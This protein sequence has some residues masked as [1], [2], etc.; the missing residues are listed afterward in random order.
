MTNRLVDANSPYLLQHAQNPVDWYPWGPEA[1]EKARLEDKPIFLSI[2][3]AA[4][5]WCH[6][7]AH[8]SFEDPETARIL[9]EHFVN[10]KVDRE[11]RP[12]LDSIYMNAVVAMTGSGGWPM[13]LFLTPEG[14]PV[15]G[16]TYFPPQRRYNL[17]AFSEILLTVARL[18]KEDRQRLLESS[19]QIT[20]HLRQNTEQ[21]DAVQPLSSEALEQAVLNLAQAY[22]WKNGGWGRAPK[23]PQPMVIELLLRRAANGD[24]FAQEM[25]EHV[26]FAM[27]RG[28]MY[29]V[30]GG[31][32]ARYSTDERWL[33]PHF[34]K[35]LYDNAQLALAY[36]H[37]FLLTGEPGFRRTCE[38]TLDFVIREMTHP[39]GGFFSNL[40]ADSEGEEGK[41]YLWTLA[42]IRQAIPEAAEMDFLTAAYGLSEAGNFAGRTVLQRQLD[43]ASLAERF[44]IPLAEVPA[45]LARL[46]ANLLRKRIGRTR[47]GTDDKV[48]TA[49]NALMLTAFAE[50]GRYLK[51]S[52]YLE[53]ARR[54]GDFLLSELYN[55][56]KLLRTWRK[57]KAG[58]TAYLEDHAALVLALLALYQS[59]PQT[60]WFAAARELTSG[61]LQSFRDPAAGFFDT[62]DDQE[63]LITRPKDLQ[64]NA[65]PSG[66]ALAALALLQM[67]AFT[68]RGEWRDLAEE[69]LRGVQ[70]DAQ[71]YPTAFAFWLQ[72]IHT[73]LTHRQEA[74]ILGRADDP[75]RQA[76]V[77]ALWSKFRPGLIAAI[78]ED[79]LQD[80]SPELLAGKPLL[81]GKATAYIC[82]NF[83]CLRPVTRPDELIS[84][85]NQLSKTN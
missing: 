45:R 69:A 77:D 82:E 19:E 31:G 79:P 70:T 1:L 75:A 4:C 80:G 49:W 65:T 28:G 40:D 50:A 51:R 27:N 37:A 61:M 57:G 16:G 44:H 17:P 63:A 48:V 54:N 33:V 34:E 2:G 78:S 18:W 20:T 6:V 39:Q 81:D 24:H 32:F 30:V 41:F 59:D 12:D 25:A 56:K 60:R 35:M 64:D 84:Q 3:Y 83:V 74:A 7:M 47:L 5:H 21:M 11:E 46:H 9:N 52:D 36:L 26:L 38:E 62:R 72:A 23:F 67:S 55:G 22:D 53:I 43:D 8:E 13:S 76:L 10:I 71:R 58:N 85:L 68:A 73:T 14:M 15:Y 66:N 29:D 42:E